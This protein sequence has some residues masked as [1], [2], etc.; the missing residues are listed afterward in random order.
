MEET[1]RVEKNKVVRLQ[2]ILR[3]SDGEVLDESGDQ[4]LVYIQGVGQIIPGLEK[5]VEGMMMG[6]ERD[7][8]V[9]PDDAYGEFREDALQEVPRSAFGD[10]EVVVGMAFNARTTDGKTIPV[11]VK[12]IKEDTVIVDFNHPLAGKTLHFWVKVVGLRDAT[13]E[14]LE[15]GHIH[16]L[17]K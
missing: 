4:P 2:Y 17:E 1:E 3:L 9:Q 8:V 5:G 16:D 15:H 7:V 12:E 11:T 10:Q 14:E 13:P 6:E